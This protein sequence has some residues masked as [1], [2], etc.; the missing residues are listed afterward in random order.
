MEEIKQ[1]LAAVGGLIVLSVGFGWLPTKWPLNRP[2]KVLL[3][4]GGACGILLGVVQYFSATSARQNSW[5]VLDIRGMRCSSLYT[6]NAPLSTPDDMVNQ[7]GCQQQRTPIVGA[8]KVFCPRENLTYF[9]FPTQ[10][11]CE[12][13]LATYRENTSRTTT[14]P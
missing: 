8:A 7:S 14:P 12:N 9:L 6:L 11:S 3:V 5:Y 13:A 2:M 10:A 1:L 4:L